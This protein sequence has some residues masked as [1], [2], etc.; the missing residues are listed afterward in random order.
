MVVEGHHQTAHEHDSAEHEESIDPSA[1]RSPCGAIRAMQPNSQLVHAIDRAT[2]VAVFERG[3]RILSM[4]ML[5]DTDAEH[6]AILL[7]HMDPPQGARILDAGCGIGEVARLMRDQRPDLSFTL[8]N[9][10]QYQ[11]DLAPADMPKLLAGFEAIPVHD[12]SFDV[13]MFNFSICHTAD[14]LQT[15]RE[16]ARVLRPGGQ[17]FIFDMERVSGDNALMAAH[18]HSTA[19]PW[20]VTARTARQAGLTLQFRWHPAQ[21]SNAVLKLCSQA[22]F[23]AVFGGTRPMVMV[24]RRDESIT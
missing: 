21:V 3:L 14:W 19:W 20:Q 23:D 10:S 12:Q 16:A 4:W 2:S 18:C 1:F 22:E 24:L 15:L 11:L 6:C 13:V 5:A 17:V 9:I 8:L 7:E